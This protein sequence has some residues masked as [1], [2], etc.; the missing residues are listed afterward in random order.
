MVSKASPLVA[1]SRLG[2]PRWRAWHASAVIVALTGAAYAVSISLNGFEALYQFSRWHEDWNIDE[3]LTA[4]MFLGIASSALLAVH[5]NYLKR[6]VKRREDAERT[7]ARALA[8][9]HQGLSMFDNNRRLVICNTRYAELHGLPPELVTPGTPFL[10]ILQHV[11]ERLADRSTLPQDLV[12]KM[13]KSLAA[14][15]VFNV[16]L[17][18]ADGRAFF[19]VVE[20]TDDGGWVSTHED[21]THRRELETRLA[22]LARHDT[23]T[24]LANRAHLRS[25][26]NEALGRLDGEELGILHIDLRQF[27]QVNEIYGPTVGDA[28]LEEVASRLKACARTTDI[29][30]RVGG[31]EFA[32]LQG[33]RKQPG[34][35]T[36]LASQIIEAF[37]APF[38]CG[39]H[40]FS[41]ATNIGIALAPHDG[42]EPDALLKNAELALDL[43]KQ[44]GRGMYRFFEHQM[45]Q[46]MQVRRQLELDLPH[47]ISAGEFEL[48]YQPIVNLETDAIT[49]FEALL[50]WNHHSKGRIS[51]ADFIPV[52]EETGLILPL[53]EW[54]LR[55]ACADAAGW[56]APMTVS[57]NVSPVQF[58]NPNLVLGIIG[59]LASSHLAPARLELEI[60]ETALLQNSEATLAMLHEIR[61]L[62]VRIAMDD[63][64]TG[65]SSLSYFQ[66]FP[67][68]K[69]KLDQSFIKSLSDKPSSLAILNAVAG[70]GA[71]LSIMTTAEGVETAEQL[72]QIRA[73]GIGQVQGYLL[74]RP[75]PA[76]E[77]SALTDVPAQSIG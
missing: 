19:V 71:S 18:F 43:A 39:D 1:L 63:F 21:I 13:W 20:P 22:H 23:L 75:L 25:G 48:F 3:L 28:L 72:A 31:D 44:D 40:R 68:D 9:M 58:R 5:A 53:G 76:S 49:G 34:A 73:A 17:E 8:T 61:S 30:A 65:Y 12:S 67:F 54:V 46:R 35:A 38:D 51:P 41:V 29:V 6:E 42:V 55:Q 56:P 2:S 47:A 15:E 24:G 4:L 45:D 77:L 57:V 60:T 37:S 32:I 16:L 7:M 64:G 50:R 70:L 10:S 14:G 66:S 74:G 11:H 27:K 69:I 36:T 26:L 52:A 33:Q 62:G 59:A